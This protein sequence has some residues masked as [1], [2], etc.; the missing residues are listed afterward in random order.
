[1]PDRKIK[2][3]RTKTGLT[4]VLRASDWLRLSRL[5]E[6]GERLHA[7]LNFARKYEQAERHLKRAIELD[8]R[9]CVAE[10]HVAC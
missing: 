8:P 4:A 3:L 9:P 1:M 7:D 6:I 5:Q 10:V 2:S